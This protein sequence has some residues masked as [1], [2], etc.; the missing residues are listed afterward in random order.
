MSEWMP[1]ETAPKDRTI[2]TN[3]T[4]EGGGP[5][6]AAKWLES[7]QWSGWVYD[8]DILNDA[9]PHGPMPTHWLDV[10]PPPQGA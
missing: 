6:T 3:D 1:I 9:C 2:L 4:S 8:D 7:P 10:P 5:W